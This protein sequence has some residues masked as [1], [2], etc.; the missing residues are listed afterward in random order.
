M[1]LYIERWLVAPLQLK[2]G[3]IISRIKGVPQGSVLGPILS[4]LVLNQLDKYIEEILVPSFN[5][6][7]RRKANPAYSKITREAWE[8]KCEGDYLKAKTLNKQAQQM[9]SRQPND[10]NF[11]RLWYVR[12]ADDWLAGVIG[13]KEDAVAIKNQIAQY[14]EEELKLQLSAEKTLITHARTEKAK[15]L[16]YEVHSL[17]CDTKHTG[18]QRSINGSIGLRIPYRVIKENMYKFMKGGKA[19]HRPE[20]MKDEPYSIVNQY[21]GEDRGVVQYYKMAYNLHSRSHLKYTMETSLVK[22]LAGK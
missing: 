20:R 3:T 17:H 14:L 6:G 8:A 7:T 13:T 21:Q 1:L 5:K 9:P 12:Y 11:K 16:G 15:F 22:T 10:P 4:N 2:D 18:G 19:I